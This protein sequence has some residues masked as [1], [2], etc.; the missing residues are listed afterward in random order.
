[1]D[2][3][4]C[5]TVGGVYESD[6]AERNVDLSKDCCG[7][8]VSDFC[9]VRREVGVCL[10]VD[11]WRRVGEPELG[12]SAGAKRLLLPSVTAR[13]SVN[14][15]WTAAAAQLKNHVARMCD[16]SAYLPTY[17]ATQSIKCSECD[18]KVE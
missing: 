5:A 16:C 2:A 13:Q 6:G 3:Y 17:S 14:N 4:T 8:R 18:R 11:C 12:V 7:G 1:M 15:D 10:N 9:G